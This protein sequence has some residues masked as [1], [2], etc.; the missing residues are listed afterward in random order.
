MNIAL[1][2]DKK[3]LRKKKGEKEQT[4]ELCTWVF[5]VIIAY[6]LKVKRN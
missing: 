5:F 2:V 3:T 4:E 6:L 1:Y